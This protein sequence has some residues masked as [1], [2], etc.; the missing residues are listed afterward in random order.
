VESVD[1]FYDILDFL[2]T[3]REKLPEDARLI[4]MNFSWIWA[5]FFRL[6]GLIG[7]SR[8]SP[9]WKF[10]RQNDLDCFLEMSGWQNVL[11]EKRFMLPVKIPLLG[12]LFDNF[13]V[14]LPWIRNLALNTI[15]LARKTAEGNHDDR[16]VTVLVPCKNEEDNIEHA[17]NRMP[18]F[19]KSLEIV[20]INDKSTDNT[21]R[22]ISECM[23]RCSEHSI[24]LVQGKGMGKGEAVREGMKAATGDICMILDADLTVI[25]EDLPQFYDAIKNR[26]ADFVHGTRFVYPQENDAM[27]FANLVGN[28]GFSLIFSYLLGQRTT[29]TLC[30]TKVFWRK[31]WPIFEE[32]RQILKKSDLWG[33]Y[34]LIFGASRFGLKIAQ[35]PVRYF[36]RLE[37]V[38]KMN[39]RV[40]NGLVMLR[41]AWHALFKVKFID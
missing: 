31:D 5:P 1:D 38:T 2:S 36:E 11:K 18:R 30:G 27:R 15:Y 24:K 34:N 28:M 21:E 39:K 32:M 7:F 9:H 4:Y 12:L 37:G 23:E 3:L 10:Y 33:D 22:K 25:P 26:R 8:K 16:D 13:L 40:K 29:D 41:V 17:V 20:F 35:L 14:R 6:G 19:G